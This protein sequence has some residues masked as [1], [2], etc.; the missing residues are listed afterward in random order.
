VSPDPPNNFGSSKGTRMVMK[1]IDNM[2]TVETRI[3]TS[4]VA[5]AMEYRGKVAS[6][7]M[8][9][10]KVWSLKAVNLKVPKKA[11]F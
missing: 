10:V 8:I 2:Y 1:T 4:L 3:G 7:P 5:W 9:P 11:S 6:P